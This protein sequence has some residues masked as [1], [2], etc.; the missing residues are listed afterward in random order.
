M[1]VTA[2][3]KIP[4]EELRKAFERTQGCMVKSIKAKTPQGNDVDVDSL[5]VEI[6]IDIP[7]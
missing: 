7:L 3:A 6:E 2:F 4:L 5:V 1:K